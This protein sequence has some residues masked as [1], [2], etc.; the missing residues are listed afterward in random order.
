[1]SDL[2]GAL[3]GDDIALLE[4][5]ELALL[6]DILGELEGDGVELDIELLEEEL[7]AM[8]NLGEDDDALSTSSHTT[9]ATAI[10]GSSIPVGRRKDDSSTG[11][12]QNNSASRSRTN[13][14]SSSSSSIGGSS[15]P[16][17]GDGRPIKPKGS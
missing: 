1:M 9:R 11:E 17:Q 5:D 14:E 3:E 8:L 4:D 16:S 6:N 12:D 2:F 7:L 15:S 10:D 13:E